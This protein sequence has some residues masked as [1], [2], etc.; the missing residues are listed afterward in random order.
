MPFSLLHHRQ[1]C[2]IDPVS[3]SK[4]KARES[5]GRA[6]QEQYEK[7]QPTARYRVSVDSTVT[8]RF[9]AES[10]DTF[11]HVFNCGDDFS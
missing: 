2:W 10:I 5:I 9:H 1:E 3:M 4:A 6:L 7:L 8:V 11:P